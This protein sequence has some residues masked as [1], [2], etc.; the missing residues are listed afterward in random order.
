M[1]DTFSDI[2]GHLVCRNGSQEPCIGISAVCNKLFG[3]VRFES[4]AI[5]SSKGIRDNLLAKVRQVC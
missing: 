1:T 3:K 5:A 2:R 4:T